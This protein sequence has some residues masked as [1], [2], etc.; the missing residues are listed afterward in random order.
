MTENQ[1]FL[2]LGSLWDAEVQNAVFDEKREAERNRR[3]QLHLREALIDVAQD[4]SLSVM[5][6]GVAQYIHVQRIGMM[7]LD[8]ELCGSSDRAVVHFTAIQRASSG[9]LC[10]CRTS[11][12]QLFELVPLG[13]VLRDLERRAA[14][15][16]V[17]QQHGGIA[18]RITGVWRDALSMT[19]HRGRVV[20]PWSACGLILIA[21]SN[22][23]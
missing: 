9:G 12:P 20:V 13:A 23:L 18:G 3:A 2:G 1:N 6:G 22:R 16:L 15:V 11:T 17:V 19:T 10:G 8:G 21:D 5:V 4:R 14:E 7:W